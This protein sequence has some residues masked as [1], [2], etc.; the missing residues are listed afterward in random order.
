MKGVSRA[1]VESV[2]VLAALQA[3]PGLRRLLGGLRRD[4]RGLD[5]RRWASFFAAGVEQEEL[6]EALEEL[7]ALA[8]C[9][10]DG[11]GDEDD[12]DDADSD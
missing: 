12:E 1:A 11:F 10:G 7:A 6:Q 5:A 4:V 2:P 3:A 8:Q 9:Y